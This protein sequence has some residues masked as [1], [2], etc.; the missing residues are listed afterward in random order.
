MAMKVLAILVFCAVLLLQARGAEAQP[1]FRPDGMDADAMGR[2]EGYPS[3]T[4][5]DFS[6]Q[7]C[8]VGALSNFAALF[9]SRSIPA[10][11]TAYRLLYAPQEPTVRYTLN[12]RSLDLDNYLDRQPVTGFL[13]ARGEEILVER[14]QYGRSDRDQLASYSMAKTIV[15]LLAGLAVKD[16]LI[17]SINDPAER[18]AEQLKGSEYGRTPIKALLQMSSGVSFKEDYVPGSDISVLNRATLMQEPGGSPVALRRFNTRIAPAGTRWTY[19]SAETSVLGLVVAGAT[20]R[21]LSDYALE[22]LWVPL[23]AEQPAD[24][25]VDATGREVA[26]AYFNAALRDWAR[27]GLMLAHDGMW[28]GKQVVPRDWML[29][30]TTV[31]PSDPHL[32]FSGGN[33]AGYGYQTWL[34]PGKNRQFALWGFRGQFVL[35]DPV[36]KVVLVQTAARA[37]NDEAAERELL[38]LF[39]AVSAQFAPRGR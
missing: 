19:A 1:R 3:C 34:I 22:R 14:Y 31:A 16:G 23:G 33:W 35:V 39:Q 29:A 4:R 12:G 30:A 13:I 32:R 7:R 11:A 6:E 25:I 9:P 24:W 27:L 20:G 17:R 38:A 15:A 36:T 18:Y 28:G 8:R 21:S 2:R 37:G 26:F 10:P 5:A